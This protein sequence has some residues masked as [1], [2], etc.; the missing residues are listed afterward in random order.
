MLSVKHYDV[1]A[2]SLTQ[3]LR[4]VQLSD[5][6]SHVYGADNVTLVEMVSRQQPDLIVMTG[7]MLDRND[8][9]ADVVLQLIGTM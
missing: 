6:H 2:E 7:D 5:L 3:P 8:A 9:N 4:I 1:P